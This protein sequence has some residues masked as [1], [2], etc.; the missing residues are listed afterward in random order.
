MNWFMRQLLYTL[1]AIASKNDTT[2]PTD[3]PA[4]VGPGSGWLASLIGCGGR[5]LKANHG[6]HGQGSCLAAAG[7]VIANFTSTSAEHLL[8]MVL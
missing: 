2:A 8:V 5:G 1:R 7:F 4:K 6:K 3:T